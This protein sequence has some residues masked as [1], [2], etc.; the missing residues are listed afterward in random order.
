[1]FYVRFNG[2]WKGFVKDKPFGFFKLDLPIVTRTRG[3]EG[4]KRYTDK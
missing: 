4:E 1:M 3:V 2:M